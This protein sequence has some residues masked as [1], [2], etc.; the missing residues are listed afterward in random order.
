MFPVVPMPLEDALSRFL[1]SVSGFM[2]EF[3]PNFICNGSDDGGRY[4]YENQVRERVAEEHAG[5][6]RSPSTHTHM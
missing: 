1:I 2:E 5:L 4:D 3:D 6:V